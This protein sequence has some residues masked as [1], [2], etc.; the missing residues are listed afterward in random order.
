MN[1]I[2]ALLLSSALSLPAAAQGERF[3]TLN[4]FQK[5]RR[6]S[7][8]TRDRALSPSE[9]RRLRAMDA[10]TRAKEFDDMAT[11]FIA[12]RDFD[13]AMAGFL[14]DLFRVRRPR[15][16]GG[17]LTFTSLHYRFFDLMKENRPWD[18]L[19][20]STRIMPAIG[21][22]E[23]AGRMVNYYGQLL[24]PEHVAAVKKYLEETYIKQIANAVAPG[25]GNERSYEQELAKGPLVIETGSPLLA[26]VLSDPAFLNRHPTTPINQNRKRAAAVFRV[27]L[28]DEM[29]AVILPDAS[30]QRELELA[31]L[32]DGASARAQVSGTPSLVQLHAQDKKCSSCH[33]KL[34]PM[35]NAFRGASNR[36]N[37]RPVPGR[38]VFK[39]KSGELVNLP[40]RNF[41]EL[42]TTL[43]Q[44]PEY[45]S[46]QVR[47]FWDYFVGRDI[48][49]SAATEKALVEKFN[50]VGRRPKDFA[51][52]L[53]RRPEFHRFPKFTT[54]TIDFQQVSGI[55]QSCKSCHDSDPL[56]PVVDKLPF[57]KFG[58]PGEHAE[59]S[60]QM[61][62]QLDLLG[63]GS[64][65]KM[66]PASAG[67]KLEEGDRALITAW[68][69]GGAKQADDS[70]GGGAPTWNN[71]SLQAALRKKLADEGR[72]F[73]LRATFDQTAKRRM[74][75]E[76][77]TATYQAILK[78]LGVDAP[79]AFYTTTNFRVRNLETGQ[80]LTNPTANYGS[81]LAS[82][83]ANLRIQAQ[84]VLLTKLIESSGLVL[85]QECARNAQSFECNHKNLKDFDFNLEA[86]LALHEMLHGYRPEA[87]GALYAQLSKYVRD[88]LGK[89][90][91]FTMEGRI[92]DYFQQLVVH[93]QFL[94][95]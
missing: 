1:R 84:R 34:D 28:C 48:P 86:I 47:H 35:A 16:S 56:A 15:I 40:Y 5:F 79:N 76:Q 75:I 30:A 24:S 57:S 46:C 55:L 63:D 31:A 87:G 14:S 66:P 23:S 90:P 3:E 82:L 4:D 61:V 20:L 78:D 44:Q 33:Y 52:Y 21:G 72:D 41:Q 10:A 95:Y 29:K 51:A 12:S 32:D 93:S 27:F 39:R 91:D 6:L 85:P 38:L 13:L 83:S 53:V 59:I 22:G 9:V 50:A 49:M 2:I 17:D 36:I 68:L 45:A 18:D 37:N 69:A 67:W 70:H 25:Y 81:E 8:L 71:P 60:E 80:V 77:V 42:A 74:T 92:A 19:L 7:L 62:K 65:A 58:A 11:R 88:Y 89:S 26:G 54:D 73:S 94:T 64:K 43:V